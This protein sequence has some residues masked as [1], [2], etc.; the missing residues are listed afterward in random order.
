MLNRGGVDAEQKKNKRRA[1]REIC[2]MCIEKDKKQSG[3]RAETEIGNICDRE[4]AEAEQK[5][6][7]DRN[8]Q[9]L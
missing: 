5:K 3:R 8:Q 1:E 9:Y 2:N 4:R 7:R 6:S